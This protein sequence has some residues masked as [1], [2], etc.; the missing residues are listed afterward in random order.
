MATLPAMPLW[1]DS[2]IADTTHLNAAETGAYMMLL[3]CMWRSGG[4]IDNN[5]KKLARF[6]R[7]SPSQWQRIKPTIM[8]FLVEDAVGLT[9]KRLLTLYSNASEKVSLK[10][11]LGSLGGQ[12]T[13]LKNKQKAVANGTSDGTPTITITK[14]IKRSIKRGGK[15]TGLKKDYMPSKKEAVNYWKTRGRTD[16]SYELIADE[17]LTYCKAHGKTYKDWDAAWKTWYINSVKF[18]RKTDG[19]AKNGVI[20]PEIDAA[21]KTAPSD[22][23]KDQWK[24]LLA[25]APKSQYA[26]WKDNL[27]GDKPKTFEDMVALY[28]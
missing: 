20:N 3:I 23:T 25:T 28:E 13:A 7:C 18:Q 17:F 24:M 22:R 8:E 1:T 10:R 11:H 19:V 2:F 12:A 15:N 4:Y 16:L 5:D 6:A 21:L 26:H 14:P 9:Q 27:H